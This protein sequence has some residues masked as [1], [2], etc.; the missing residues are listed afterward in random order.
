VTLAAVSPVLARFAAE[1]TD[2]LGAGLV[3]Q[4]EGTT[5]ASH[6]A[7]SPADGADPQLA[8]AYLAQVLLLHQRAQAALHRTGDPEDVAIS[9]SG[10][11]LL[12]RPLPSSPYIWTLLTG[13][14]A[15]LALTRALMRRF[16][17]QIIDA[18]PKG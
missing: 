14:G 10:G 4:Q 15:N 11:L 16:L 12:A 6:P 18:L 8:D 17:P 1:V 2:F 5:V 13:P 9:T 3:D 7:A